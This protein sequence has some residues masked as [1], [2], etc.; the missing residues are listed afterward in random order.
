MPL[1][2]LLSLLLDEALPLVPIEAQPASGGQNRIAF[3]EVEAPLM[4]AWALH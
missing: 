3:G 4:A 1:P 2:L